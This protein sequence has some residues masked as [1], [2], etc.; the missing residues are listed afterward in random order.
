M[1][2]KYKNPKDVPTETLSR[3]LKQLSE[4]FN[5]KDLFE[6]E[7]TRRVPAELDRDADLV[8]SEAANRLVDE[9]VK[10]DDWIKFHYG[11]VYNAS[12]Q[13]GKSETQL[14]RWIKKGALIDSEG[15]VYIRTKGK[16]V[17]YKV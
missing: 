2:T 11:T 9:P 13:T 14:H 1:S 4:C 15:N 12:K 8:L 7:F 16:L 10:L 3:R 6:M 5:D 17:I